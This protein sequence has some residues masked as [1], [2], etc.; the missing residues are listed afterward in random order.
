[1]HWQQYSLRYEKLANSYECEYYSIDASKY[2]KVN[3][4]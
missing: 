1:M 3:V 4:K 2:Y